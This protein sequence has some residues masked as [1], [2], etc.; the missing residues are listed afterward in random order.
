MPDNANQNLKPR[1][2]IV[3]VIG[4]VDHGKTTLLDY[5]RQTNIAAREAGGI[6]QSIGAYEIEHNGKKIT[7]IDTPGHEAFTKMRARGAN[8]ADLAILVVAA[9]EGVKPQTLESVKILEETKTPF[10]IAIT[11]TDKPNANVEKVKQELTAAGVLLEGYG[12]K[13]SY[14]PVSAKTGAGINELL[15]LILLAAELENLTYDPAKPGR[16]YILEVRFDRRRGVEVSV[17][18]KDGTLKQNRPIATPSGKGKIKIL[19]NFRG[20][21]VESLIPSAPALVLGWEE[22]PRVGEEFITGDEAVLEL[23][24]RMETKL[25]ARPAAPAVAVQTVPEKGKTLNII[26]K[27]ADAGSLEALAG[28]VKAMVAGKAAEVIKEEV[29]DVTDNDVKFAIPLGAVIF[30]FK[31]R[32]EK[33]AKI[34][35]ES[36]G[37]KIIASEIIYQLVKNI[38][39]LLAQ[40]ENRVVAELEVLAVFNQEKPERQVIGGKVT[41]GILRNGAFFEI[42]RRGNTTGKGKIINLQSGKKDTAAVEEGKEAGLLVGSQTLIQIGDKLIVPEQTKP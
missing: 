16:G 23:D 36:N 15:D 18:V 2:P 4:H 17:I 13:I 7:F 1:P 29:G 28:I 35:A 26:L 24:R 39:D 9:D 8:V 27:A 12:G 20:E 6:T 30:A 32:A 25:A 33:S 41:R 22:L 34:L 31:N 37:V 40:K 5:L 21:R 19:E 38:E 14:E 42:N 11:K 10:I 3:V